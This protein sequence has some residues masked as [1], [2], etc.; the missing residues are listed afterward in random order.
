MAKDEDGRSETCFGFLN[1]PYIHTNPYTPRMKDSVFSHEDVAVDI[2]DDYSNDND[3][4]NTNNGD[5]LRNDVLFH[6]IM[7]LIENPSPCMFSLSLS[8]LVY[9]ATHH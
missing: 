2:S 9:M 7:L 8:L 4:N 5:A 1:F 6:Y 3:N